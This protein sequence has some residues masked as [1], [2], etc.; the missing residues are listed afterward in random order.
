MET[1][2]PGLAFG[3]TRA[4]GHRPSPSSSSDS[5]GVFKVSN[6]T[7]DGTEREDNACV[8]ILYIF[9]TAVGQEGGPGGGAS[10][11]L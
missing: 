10:H 6:D 7:R 11:F 3:T 9:L 5:S 1:R 4:R 2:N 8:A